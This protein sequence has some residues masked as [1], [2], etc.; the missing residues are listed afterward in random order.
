V[1]MQELFLK[2]KEKAVIYNL[3]TVKT[4]NLKRK[5]QIKNL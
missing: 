3:L 1:H 2:K 5:N 4:K